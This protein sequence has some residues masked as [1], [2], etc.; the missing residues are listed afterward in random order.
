MHRAKKKWGQNFLID[1]QIIDAIV[2]SIAPQPNDIMVEIGPGQGAL[3][4]ALL[5]KLEKLD[6]IEIDRDLIP[7]LKQKSTALGTLQIMEQDVLTI[8]F[9]KHYPQQNIRLVGNLPY[10]IS[11]PLLFHLMRFRTQIIDMHFMLQ[12]EV[13]DRICAPPGNKT[14]GRLSLMLQY[15]CQVEKL[16]EVPPHAFKPAP[17]VMS[18]IIRLTP[19]ATTTLNSS[20]E[21]CFQA[22]VKDAF[23]MRR[24]TLA[25]NL[26]HWPGLMAQCQAL[27][28]DP[29]ARAE[30]LSLEQFIALAK[31]VECPTT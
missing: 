23:A 9:A 18:A 3:S 4:F 30:T 16:F 29:R 25:N 17:K 10:L 1:T 19:H 27:H 8:D 12:K 24:K 14:Y 31:V 28:I 26:K 20:Q 5:P 15:Y 21:S 2:Q 13:V 22:L 11:S 6:A 7:L